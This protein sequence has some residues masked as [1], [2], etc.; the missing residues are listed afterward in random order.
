MNSVSFENTGRQS[1]FFIFLQLQKKIWK[2]IMK[3]FMQIKALSQSKQKRCHSN[4]SIF[5]HVNSFLAI[6]Q[7]AFTCSKLTIET[8]E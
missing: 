4:M 2:E 5:F 3:C 8:L 7:P 1:V 6:M